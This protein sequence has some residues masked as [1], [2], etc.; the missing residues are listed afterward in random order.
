MMKRSTRLHRAEFEEA[1]ARFDKIVKNNLDVPH[2][3]D[4]ERR[5]SDACNQCS[6]H[7]RHAFLLLL[8]RRA[9]IIPQLILGTM[10]G[11]DQTTV[12]RYLQFGAKYDDD[13]LVVTPRNITKL[14]SKSKTTKELKEIL[15]DRQGG[16]IIPDGTLVKTTRPQNSTEQKSNTPARARCLP[17]VQ[18][19]L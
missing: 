13:V 5:K 6:L 4:D 3:R 15:P 19:P 9:H 8:V 16:E 18:P 10:F 7:I 11:I 1:L 14:I 2:F 17:L 12:S